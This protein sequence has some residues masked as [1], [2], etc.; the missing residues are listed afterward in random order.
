MSLTVLFGGTIA[1]LL[2]ILSPLSLAAARDCL[3]WEAPSKAVD[4]ATKK[5]CHKKR[6]PLLLM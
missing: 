5:P 1:P 6:P 4:V 2:L 3:D